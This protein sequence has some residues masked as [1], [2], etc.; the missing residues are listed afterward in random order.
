LSEVHQ[1]VINHTE[2]SERRLGP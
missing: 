1:K 2:K